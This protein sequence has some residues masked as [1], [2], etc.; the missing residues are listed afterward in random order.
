MQSLHGLLDRS[1]V[2]ESMALKNVH[3]VELHPFERVVDGCDD[4]LSAQ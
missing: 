4:S 1:V 3:V 2:V